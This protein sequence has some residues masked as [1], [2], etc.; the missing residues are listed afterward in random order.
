M[1]I[2]LLYLGALHQ[3]LMLAVLYQQEGSYYFERR[4]VPEYREQKTVIY[5]DRHIMIFFS[6][7]W[8]NVL[9]LINV[10]YP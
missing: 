9:I 4:V 10:L 5:L 7:W 3:E 8:V 6:N 2:G 1:Q